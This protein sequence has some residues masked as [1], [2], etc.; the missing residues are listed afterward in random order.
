[1]NLPIW[2][3]VQPITVRFALYAVHLKH[4]VTIYVNPMHV[5]QYSSKKPSGTIYQNVGLAVLNSR[6]SLYLLLTLGLSIVLA[7]SLSLVYIQEKT[8][9][10][11]INAAAV[12]QLFTLFV[13]IYTILFLLMSVAAWWLVLNDESRRNAEI[14]THQQ[15]A[16]L[17]DEIAA[18]EVTSK[19]L[20]DARI[21]AERANDA[22]S[23]YVIGISH[24]LRTPLNSILGYSQLLPKTRAAL[25]TRQNGARRD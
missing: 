13:K 17:I 6:V 2:R 9:L 18:H 25:R 3:A 16:L 15:T 19:D 20:Q 12:P 8:Y 1:M 24:E 5:G 21:S 7:V 4:A 11:T 14:E 22:K 10:E 23:R